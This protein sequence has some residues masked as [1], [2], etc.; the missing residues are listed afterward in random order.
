[1]NRILTSM[2]LVSLV[3]IAVVAMANDPECATQ[4]CDCEEPKAATGPC[5]SG[6]TQCL[7]NSNQNG[8]CGV[9]TDFYNDWPTGCKKTGIYD[10]GPP[11]LLEGANCDTVSEPCWRTRPCK[12]GIGNTCLKDP[13]AQWGDWHWNNRFVK[14]TCSG[15]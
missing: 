4:N 15:S 3:A 6:F 7:M 11:V 8:D 9:G 14:S 10:E 13:E 12:E 2:V 1:M 5:G